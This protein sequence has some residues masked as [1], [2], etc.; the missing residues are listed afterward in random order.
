[1]NRGKYNIRGINYQQ[2]A[3][4]ALFLQYLR[5]ND[6]ESIHLEAPKSQDFDL[7]FKD[8]KIIC[9]AKDWQGQFSTSHLLKILKN[10][11]NRVTFA[12]N[13]EILIVA[14]N[15]SDRLIN[16]IENYKYLRS[17]RQKLKPR[18]KNYS[19][20]ELELLPRIRFWQV[21]KNILENIVYAL[22]SEAIG[23]WLPQDDLR[24]KLKAILIDKF[25][26]GSAVE[27]VYTK[28]EFLTNI[29]SISKKT[30]GKTTLFN[31]EFRSLDQ[32]FSNLI[33]DIK[34]NK[35]PQWGDY[36]MSSLSAQPNKM[37]FVLERVKKEK[38]DLKEWERLWNVISLKPYYYSLF[39]IFE[40]NLDNARNKEYIFQFIKANIGEIKRFYHTDFF[41]VD[42]VKI[43]K[44]IL[45]GDKS[46][47]FIKNA[48]EVVKK[49]ISE[50]RDDIFYLKTQ[51]DSSWERGEI[52]KLLKEVYEKADPELKD[53]IYK[54]IVDT[55]NLVKDEGEFSHYTPREIFGI[56][57]AW[58]ENDFEKRLPILTGVLS[59]QYDSSYKKFGKRLEFKGW[60]YMGGVTSFWGHRYSVSDRHF[61]GYTLEPVLR[62][63][64]DKNKSKN[65]AWKFIIKHCIS[66]TEEV[67]KKRPD[68]LNRA[69]I[70]I[71]L[72]RYESGGRETSRE[73]FGILKEFILSRKG[74]PHKSDLIYQELRGKGSFPKEK[75][76]KLVK[77]SIKKYDIPV[78]VFV[79]EIVSQLA[80]EG[81]QDAKKTMKEWLKNPKYYERFRSEINIL[82]NIRA[83]LE[84]DFAY[85]IGMFEE[86][87]S[88]KQFI[89]NYDSFETYEFAIL[90]YDILKTE[91][92]F[93][94]G[95]KILKRLSR[96][97][98][99]SKNQQIILCFSLFNY[100]GNDESDDLRLLEK[101]YKEFVD[102]LLGDCNND[103][104]RIC[105]KLSFSQA[106][107][108]LVQFAGR[109]AHHKKIKEAL[110]IVE[111]F[112]DDPDPYLPNKDP[113]DPKNEYNEH[114]RIEEGKE[115]GTITSTR[116]WCAWV[117]M[118]CSVLSGRDYIPKIIALTAKLTKDKNWYVKHMACFALSQ[119]AQNRLTVLP[120]N[121]DVLFF[122]DNK[123]T[124]LKRAKRV[125]KVA[126]DLLEE[127]AKSS[128][129]V[130]KALA[131]SILH[132][133]D[134]LRALNKKDALKFV[135]ILAKFPDEANA[136]AAPLFIFFAEFRKNAFKKWKWA[137]TNLYN[138]LSP[139]KFDDKKFKKI[140]LEVMDNLPPDKRFPF[141][142]QFEHLIRNL[143]YSLKDAERLF[144]IAYKYLNH[145]SNKYSHEVFRVIYMSI[146]EGMEKKRH[147]CKWYDL[148]I[149]CLKKEKEFYDKNF[150]KNKATEMSWWPSYYN[151][152]ILLLVYQQGSK[153]EFLD[154]FD[155]ITSFPKE[156]E[157]HDSPNIVSLLG[158]FSKKNKRVKSIVER[159]FQR[160]QIKYYDLRNEWFADDK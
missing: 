14:S 131:K 120:D 139:E 58:L 101:V 27:K 149:K 100:R 53:K 112:I 128:N 117:L 10:I 4:I 151:E 74:I 98:E 41:D 109:L 83:V 95:L 49:L 61:I 110:R 78:N 28:A 130:Q 34:G 87:I 143:N 8:R 60:E 80:K 102:S 106:R 153:K 93:A 126:F 43:A 33:Q 16:N 42:V 22:F 67:S 71:V 85:A 31:D 82:Q 56:L 91:K 88:S 141:V 111:V 157:I 79:E 113:E 45:E 35:K 115:P 90:L 47:K 37:F 36:D 107:E 38:F 1:M 44:K 138:D 50:R 96:E 46:N 122:G 133:F 159:L 2:W 6:F 103:I 63:Y 19:D 40:N 99:L 127:I 29:Q 72:K 97:K 15:V 124:A 148:Y 118:K 76:W 155:I 145:L 12:E 92:G 129:N 65:R 7:L 51:R 73:A 5:F 137:M 108:A 20:A 17:F 48:F 121:R 146:K 94:R 144:K 135:K 154:A 147:F 13:D 156:L 62:E 3:A 32:Q 59:D 132:V 158:N 136:E 70:P 25:Y 24:E 160:N 125:E 11:R 23:F 54:L 64:Y 114:K 150:T 66:K 152:D 119:L 134:H 21:S 30:V 68:F 89:H 86:F 18:F 142:V 75:K 52:A 81:H 105:E 123:K 57:K 77:V 26:E 69:V 84:S 140:L 39:Q 104:K 9:E 55:F 116:G